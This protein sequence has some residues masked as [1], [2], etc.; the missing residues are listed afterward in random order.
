MPH[1]LR[2]ASNALVLLRLRFSCGL[3]VGTGCRRVTTRD[4]ARQMACTADTAACR[5]SLAILRAA[6]RNAQNKIL[7]DRVC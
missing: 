3:T 4:L 7:H 5:F 2:A 6:A 1:E